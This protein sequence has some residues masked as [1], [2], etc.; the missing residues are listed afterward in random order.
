MAKREWSFMI[1]DR[2][3]GQY[4]EGVTTGSG[5][6]YVCTAGAVAPPTIYSDERGSV[7]LTSTATGHGALVNKLALVFITNGYCRFWTDSSVTSLDVTYLMSTGES[8]FAKG[9]SSS[10]HM[11]SVDSDGGRPYTLW[12]PFAFETTGGSP[13]DTLLDL[14]AGLEIYDAGC[15]VHTADST[16]TV[17]FGFKNAVE[18]GDEDG[19]LDGMLLTTAGP[20]A[21]YGTITDGSL[22]DYL[23]FT[24]GKL[25]ALLATTITGSDVV[26]T[27]GGVSRLTYKTDGTIKSLVYTPSSSDTAYGFL[28][29]KYEKMMG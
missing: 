17:D 5:W 14:P 3:K 18:S 10:R 4:K 8:G 26:S 24:N 6:M 22:I 2:S 1:H 12:V 19:L 7:S 16:E 13:I 21:P 25:G 28:T 15:Y 20:V 27:V 29:I 11:L 9:V 23:A